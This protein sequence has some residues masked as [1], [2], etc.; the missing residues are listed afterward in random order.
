VFLTANVAS[1]H[2]VNRQG[3]SGRGCKKQRLTQNSTTQGEL[4]R[5]L[6]CHRDRQCSVGSPLQPSSRHRHHSDLVICLQPSAIRYT[7]CLALD[8]P[9]RTASSLPRLWQAPAGVGSSYGSRQGHAGLGGGPAVCPV[10]CAAACRR[11]SAACRCLPNLRGCLLQVAGLCASYPHCVPS[12]YS[13]S[14]NPTLAPRRRCPPAFRLCGA[15]A[16]GLLHL[17]WKEGKGCWQPGQHARGPGAHRSTVCL[18]HLACLMLFAVGK[19]AAG[20]VLLAPLTLTAAA[21][22]CLHRPHLSRCRA[23]PPAAAP[24]SLL[25]TCCLGCPAAAAVHPRQLQ[26]RTGSKRQRQLP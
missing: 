23:C 3:F 4:P 1:A 9:A 17:A 10:R 14:C 11:R 20:G 18:F 16:C 24:G 8:L 6:E 2:T 15:C 12:L 13:C 22:R 26:R 7:S 21:P 25:K 19:S 5:P